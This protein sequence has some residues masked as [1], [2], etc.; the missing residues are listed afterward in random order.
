MGILEDLNEAKKNATGAA[1]EALFSLVSLPHAT[2]AELVSA[3]QGKSF[4]EASST[5]MAKYAAMGNN[6]EREKSDEIVKALIKVR[7][8]SK[9]KS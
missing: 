5:V 7:Q 6:I 8:K 3:T 2:I 4:D 9:V 1:G